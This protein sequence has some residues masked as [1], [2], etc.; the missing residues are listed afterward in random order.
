MKKYRPSNGT[1]GCHFIEKHCMNCLNCDPNPEGKKQ[2]KILMRTMLY[3]VD[4]KRY[5]SEWVYLDDKPTCTE[6]KKWDW[7]NDGDP[8][9]LD[10]P[11]APIPV[12][13][14]QLMLFSVTDEILNK[15]KKENILSM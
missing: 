13:P 8:D 12:A 9:D 1:E 6:Y 4:D 15:S 14:N 7:G 5:P 10:N 11:K 3:N 2:C